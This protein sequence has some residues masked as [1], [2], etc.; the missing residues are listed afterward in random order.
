MAYAGFVINELFQFD[1]KWYGLLLSNDNSGFKRF[2]KV[3]KFYPGGCD[4]TILDG[5]LEA[6]VKYFYEKDRK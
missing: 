4:W 5:T 6:A 1:G 3:N 2:I